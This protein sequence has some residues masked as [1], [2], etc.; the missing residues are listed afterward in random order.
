MGWFL[1]F[2]TET[3]GII[4]NVVVSIGAIVVC[5][6]AIKLMATNSGIKLQKILKRTLHTFILLILGV[7]AGATLPII[8]AVFMDITHM[9]LSWF[10]HNWLMLGLY[11]CPFFF[12]V[13]I[14]PALYFHYT[15]TVSI[16]SNHSNCSWRLIRCFLGSI[17]DWTTCAAADAL[18]LPIP[19]AA[20]PGADYLQHSFCICANADLHVL[21]GGPGL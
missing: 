20:H 3:E 11:F 1:V 12:G 10:T 13:A 7:V 14:V 6:L 19:G 17:S 8:I 2:Y 18:P 16:D 21:H 15:A 9:P 5:G 4:L